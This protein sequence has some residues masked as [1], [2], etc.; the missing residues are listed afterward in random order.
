MGLIEQKILKNRYVVQLI[1]LAKRVSLPGFQKVPVYDVLNLFIK[2][3]NE[4]VIA[5]RAAAVSFSFFLA[6][7]PTMIFFFTL[8]PFIP[9]DG[10]Q[11]ELMDMITRALP[12]ATNE[13]VMG[14][15]QEVVT[16]PSSGVLSL[17]FILALFFASNGFKS[18]IIAFNSSVNIHKDRSFI[19]LQLVSLVL[20]V[21][22]SFTTIVTISSIIMEGYLLDLLLEYDF[23]KQNAIY[24]LILIGDWIL[25]LGMIFF[26]VSFLYYYAPKSEN[27]FKLISTG[28]TFATIIMVAVIYLFN[29]YINNFGQYNVLY[30]SIGTLLIVM[31][32]IY[33]NSF[34][35]LIGFE[36]NSSILQAKKIQS[37]NEEESFQNHIIE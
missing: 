24:Y 23:I 12:D 27:R 25:L 22:F 9:I 1:D 3:I 36:I 7:F 21:V 18:I 8:I 33:I 15:I 37:L 13:S 10:F 16:R 30:G 34:I 11:Q 2:A 31:L 20:V 4:G 28:S 26:M 29:I 32:W 5:Q 14:V 17:G 6:I 35:L 19:S